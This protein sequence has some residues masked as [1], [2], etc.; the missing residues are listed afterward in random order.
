[1]KHRT[2]SICLRTTDYSETSQVLAFFTRDRGLVRVIAKGAKRPKSKTGGAVDLFSEGDLV[3]T[4]SRS[5]GLGTLAEFAETVSH[6]ALRRG[7]EPINAGLYLLEITG[8]MLPIDDPHPEVFDLLHNALARLGNAD[9]P[10]QAVVAY[11]QW[12]FLRHLGLL[13]EM[14]GCVLCGQAIEGDREVWF[15]SREGGLV[16]PACQIGHGERFRVDLPTQSGLTA[17]GC[18]EMG[19]KV[20]FSEPHARQV[21][22]LLGYHITQ[23]LGKALRT[24]PGLL[25]PG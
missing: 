1:M 2:Q 22:R 10:V 5:G 4:D 19:Q 9:A 24:L 11:F 23:Q 13:G 7:V 18:A 21:N 20:S 12:R 17:L 6:T 14:T 8:Q 25:G 3:Y 16:C 15:S